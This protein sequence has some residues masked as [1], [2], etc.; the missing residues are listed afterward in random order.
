MT[1]V[2]RSGRLAALVLDRRPYDLAN[3]VPDGVPELLR[4]RRE[5]CP[6][7]GLYTAEA[8]GRIC[9][10]LTELATDAI[11]AGYPVPCVQASAAIQLAARNGESGLSLRPGEHAWA[12]IMNGVLMFRR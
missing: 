10:R 11:A 2:N 4:R 6:G 9:E 8:T 7:G 5:R 3:L 12:I 1:I